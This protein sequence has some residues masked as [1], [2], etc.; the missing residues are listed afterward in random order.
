[1]D[2]TKDEL[3]LITLCSFEQLSYKIK[4]VLLDKLNLKAPDFA[5]FEPQLIKSLSRGV[6]NKVKA[7]YFSAEYRSFVL[8][9]LERRGITCVTI[10]SQNYP[11]ML[12]E[13]PFPP[14]VL[15]CKGNL[16]LLNTR[17][18]SVVGSRRTNSAAALQCKKTCKELTQHFTVVT[19]MADGA[20][21]AAVEG[22]AESG[23]IISVLAYGFDYCYPAFNENLIKKVEKNGLLITEFTPQTSPKQYLFPVRNRIIAGLSEATLVVSAGKKSGA[24]IT[25]EYAFE[26]GRTVF[27]FPY[28]IGAASGEGCNALIK[29][30]GLLT[31][32]I[33]D[34]FGLY[35]LDFKQ[36]EKRELTEREAL[37]LKLIRE[38]GEAFVPD[39]A[40][41]TGKLPYELI[42]V[43]SSLEIK[44]LVVRLGGNRYS[45][46]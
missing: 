35:G 31:E 37:L 18:F 39:I 17:C 38:A 33:L 5:K 21:S 24:L 1:M 32:N 4:Y 40:A 25:A 7:D 36:P 14:L 10:F 20:D 29:K 45:A 11:A 26:Y 6:Y 34:I 42:P 16:G 23:K 13:T 8:R 19:G 43:L 3:N 2:Y 30:G 15:Y 12:K 44:G 28:N 41:K 46:V 27:A 22:A 9:G